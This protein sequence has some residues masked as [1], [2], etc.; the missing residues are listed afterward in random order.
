MAIIALRRLGPRKATNTMARTSDGNAR[1]TSQ[2]RITTSSDLAPEVAG[3]ASDRHADEDDGGRD[4]EGD[5]ERDAGAVDDAA[6]HVTSVAVG[7]EQVLRARRLEAA[8]RGSTR[9]GPEPGRGDPR[10]R[11]AP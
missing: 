4:H 7:A 9:R 8:R 2:I 5:D 1:N 11:S 10:T 6:E 3:D